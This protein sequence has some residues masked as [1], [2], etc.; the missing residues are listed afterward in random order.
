[1][2]AALVWLE[3]HAPAHDEFTKFDLADAICLRAWA[4]LRE[5]GILPAFASVVRRSFLDFW[6]LFNL[7]GRRETGIHPFAEDADK[8]HLL[9]GEVLSLIEDVDRET[10][11]LLYGDG[12]LILREDWSWLLA[13]YAAAE[14]ERDKRILAKCLCRHFD[15]Q[16]QDAVHCII[17][18][19]HAEELEASHPLMDEMASE[20]GPIWLGSPQEAA[21]RQS[22]EMRRQLESRHH[23]PLDPPPAARV[24]E[25]L[26]RCANGHPPS[27]VRLWQEMMLPDGATGYR[28]D[29]NPI[30]D[31][32]GWLRLN[33]YERESV[34]Q[35]ARTWVFD[36]PL[37]DAEMRRAD[38]KLAY[39][40]IAMYLA[41]CFLA[42]LR[43]GWLEEA[44]ESLWR[45]WLA[46][47][48]AYPYSHDKNKRAALLILAQSRFP[49]AVLELLHA[50]L[51][52][53]IHA[54]ETEFRA[55]DDLL[56]IWNDQV[57][58]WV[59]GCLDGDITFAQCKR[60]L[61]VLLDRQDASAIRK[62]LELLAL[63][64]SVDRPRSDVFNLA[65]R[66][67][68]QAPRET[69]PVLW[70]RTQ[71]DETYG[72]ALWAYIAGHFGFQFPMLKELD[73]S[74]LA[75]F[76]RWLEARYPEA[77]DPQHLNGEHYH[78]IDL[79]HMAHLRS[80]TA[81][82]LVELGTQE[83]ISALEMLSS[84]FPDKNW[85]RNALARARA[86]QRN[87]AWKC[88][89]PDQLLTYLERADARFAR[90]GDELMDAVLASL[91]RLQT[92]LQG[93]NP[94][95]PF[96]WNVTKDDHSGRPKGEERLSDFVLQHLRRDLPSAVIDREVQVDN[97][98]ESGIPRRT[99]IKIE[100]RAEGLSPIVLIIETKGCWND[101]LTT[102]MQSQLR[103]RYLRRLGAG[104]GLYLVGWYACEFWQGQDDKRR[105]C[106][107]A[108]SG[109][110]D[111]QAKLSALADSHSD[112]EF[113]LRVFVL[114]VCH[115]A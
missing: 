90:D 8:R 94:L 30:T 72:I 96:L 4:M 12:R 106:E 80:A 2:L 35:Y 13:R 70:T 39:T 51:D 57:A 23:P 109:P 78:P 40:H 28:I 79:D 56:S 61:A 76:Y 58:D 50:E 48:V 17:E 42:D 68:V 74:S 34:L 20:L 64:E 75:D 77:N 5:P 91:T 113:R 22:H 101:E 93:D 25:A 24:I 9:I 47:T 27:W 26:A 69:W 19:V 85:M 66:L 15:W 18:A 107:R 67:F 52:R 29:H 83:T 111:L 103:E 84:E 3:K 65:Q 14:S 98:R 63:P 104:H 88:I 41:L 1:M 86:V 97:P 36:Y 100:A 102:A 115:P 44:G 43:P 112:Q 92:L 108:A 45:R 105:R 32:P 10:S 89:E 55:L 87:R 73:A 49:D 46:A 7:R 82:A 11:S 59:H 16:D 37:S 54:G 38:G 6:Q 95:A 99:D 71:D 110:A 53:E 60:L 21:C 33:E 62:A 31:T 81:N 114:D